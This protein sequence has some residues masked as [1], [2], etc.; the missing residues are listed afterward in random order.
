MLRK[1]AAAFNGICYCLRTQVNMLIHLAAT[2][3]VVGLAWYLQLPSWEWAILVLAIAMVLAAE[4]FNTAV[5]VM[6][7][8]TTKQY[9]PLARIAKD[10]AAGAV[11]IAALGAVMVGYFVFGPYLG[12]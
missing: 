11:L 2:L 6:V 10:V 9:H 12:F 7:N 3:A 4:A 8:L 5:E 1:F